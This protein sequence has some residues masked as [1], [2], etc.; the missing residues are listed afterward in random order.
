M[1]LLRIARG[2]MLIACAALVPGGASADPVKVR[3]TVGEQHGYLVVRSLSGK[4]LAN[5]DQIT[6]ARGE[7]VTSQLILRFRDGSVHHETAVFSQHGTFQLLSYHLEQKGPAFKHASDMRVDGA[8]GQFTASTTG[9]DGKVKTAHEQ[10]TLPDDV[11]NGNLLILLGN[12]GSNTPATLSEVVAS[13]KPRI[14]KLQIS[15]AGEESFT[16]GTLRRKAIHYVVKIEIGGIAGVVA[17]LI[18]KQPADI[19]LWLA[20]GEVPAFVGEEGQLFE[21]GPIWRI[22]QASPIAPR[23]H[24]KPKANDEASPA[25]K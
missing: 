24:R 1:T 7:R 2:L 13:P 5:G 6:V 18:G 14:V 9:D 25:K 8:T 10:L 4:L 15:S 3:H 20:T 22:E 19:H 17:P 21:G 16:A 23:T 11:A 12:I